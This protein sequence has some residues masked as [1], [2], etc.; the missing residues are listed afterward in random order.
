MPLKTMCFKWTSIRS[1][2]EPREPKKP[3]LHR[4]VVS[5]ALNCEWK[6][7]HMATPIVLR[8][9]FY[10]LFRRV[11][12]AAP[13]DRA[14]RAPSLTLLDRKCTSEIEQPA[15]QGCAGT[16]PSNILNGGLTQVFIVVSVETYLSYLNSATLSRLEIPQISMTDGSPDTNFPCVLIPKPRPRGMALGTE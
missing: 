9:R 3:W 2:L 16:L 10:Y 4:A 8:M 6:R 1:N 15:L 13:C 5:V 14:D 12:W 7:R 11:K